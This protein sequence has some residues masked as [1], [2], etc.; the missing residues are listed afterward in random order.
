MHFA[1]CVWGIVRSLRFTLS[2]M[3]KYCLEPIVNAGHTYE[4]F[5]HTYKFEGN[6]TNLRSGENN[7]RLDFDEWKLLK[8][9]HIY[10]EDQDEFDRNTNYTS[11]ESLGDPWKNEYTSFVN[12]IRAIHSLHY[13]STEVE[14]A[15]KNKTYDGV[16]FLR[17]DVTYINEL[18]FYL[19]EHFPDTLFIPDFHRA[20]EGNE[21]N[22]RMAMGSL[23]TAMV[24][25]KKFEHALEYSKHKMLNSEKFTYDHLTSQNVSVIEIPF[26]FKRTRATGLYHHRDE[27]GVI[28]P[29]EQMP[30]QEAH[31]VTLLRLF[32]TMFEMLTNKK[33]HFEELDKYDKVREDLYCKPHP[34]VSV[35]QILKY[36][37]LSG[38]D[39]KTLPVR[40]LLR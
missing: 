12:H 14:K 32:Y 33:V 31:A 29:S 36:R 17:P 35:D 2:S 39:P 25:G 13:L 8:P 24:F 5:M 21:Y 37:A 40:K 38:I 18:P 27:T 4:I 1:I 28:L 30:E 7:L 22:D 3:E 11:Y 20:C 10:I 6:Y 26:R 34:Y 15:S 9:D 23:K 16:I 19:L